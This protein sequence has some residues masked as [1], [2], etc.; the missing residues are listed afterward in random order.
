M[1]WQSRQSGITFSILFSTG[2]VVR[3][4]PLA[5][6]CGLHHP[7]PATIAAMLRAL[8]PT[9][10]AV[11][12]LILA[13]CDV[14]GGTSSAQQEAEVECEAA[15]DRA[16]D[17]PPNPTVEEFNDADFGPYYVVLVE[18]MTDRGYSLTFEPSD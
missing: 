11:I 16:L 13:G 6:P 14:G 9:I 17:L 1:W 10:A 5:A 15:A 3:E 4:G 7:W 18:C 8:P 2:S 12:A